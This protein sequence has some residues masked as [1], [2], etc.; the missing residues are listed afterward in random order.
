MT[1]GIDGQDNLHAL[2]NNTSDLIWSVDR[3]YKLISSNTA[4][5]EMVMHMTGKPIAKGS[6]V[7]SDG[8]TTGQLA[9]FRKSYARAFSGETFKVT[10][11]TAVP[12]ELWSELSFYPIRNGDKVVGTACYAHDITDFKKSQNELIVAHNKLV[13]HLENT[14][15]GFIEWDDQLHVKSWSKKAE[16]IFGWTELEFIDLQKSAYSQVYKEDLPWVSKIAHQLAN[17]EIERRS[18]RHRN[19]T[20]DGRVIWC[21]WFNS[22]LKDKNGK[23]MTIM[24]QVRDITKQKKAEEKIITAS[25][26]YAFISQVNQC[27]THAE[28]EETVIKDACRVAVEFGKFKEAW[29]GMMGYMDEGC[30]HS[31]C[32]ANGAQG[33]VIQ[34]GNCYVCNDIENDALLLDWKPFVSERGWRSCIIL[35]VKKSGTVGTFNIISSAVNFFQPEEVALLKEAAGDIS[36]SLSVFEKDKHRM[37]M[38]DKAVQSGL[39]LKQA[40]SIAHVG[41]WELNFSTG[42]AEWSEEMCRIYGLDSYENVQSYDA[43]LSFIHP[44]DLEYVM[45]VSKEGERTFSN[46]SFYHRIIRKNGVIRHIL[47]QAQVEFNKESS[48]VGLTGVAHDITEM[49]ETEKALAQSEA[50]LLQIMDLMPQSIFVKDYNG[51]VVFANKSFASLYGLST[52]Q[53]INRTLTEIMPVKSEAEYLLHQDRDVILSGEATTTPE[54]SFTDYGGNKHL[55]HTLKVPFTVVGTNEKAVLGLSNDITEQK[56]A[57]TERTRMVADIVRRNKDLEQFSYI[58]SHNVRAPVANINGITEILQMSGLDKNDRERWIGELASS[59]KKLDEVIMDLNHI[60]K[61]THT[62]S[63]KKETV[64]FSELLNDIKLGFNNLILNNGVEIVSDFSAV[65][66][67]LTLRSYLY[68]IFFNLVSNSIKYRRPGIKPVVEITSARLDDKI[69]LIFKDNGLGM[70]LKKRGGQVFGLYKRFHWHVEGKGM[71][72]YMVKTQVESLGGKIGISSEVNKGT[73]FRIEFEMA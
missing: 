58:V 14:T 46:S 6:D 61:V 71:G 23:V 38:E 20:K 36:F 31:L 52:K 54:F 73:E 15:L 17:G 29:I 42:I 43:W 34:T 28:N 72:L 51:K 47:S 33:Q 39:R 66:E 67:M 8:F 64:K 40:Q 62:E 53:M 59:V 25:H 69:Q 27:I 65:D 1:E 11:Y 30:P 16:E 24:S 60:L 57:E 70:D 2:I 9:R 12:E 18:V 3:N 44:E 10:E 41:S 68:S 63:D 22:V 19:Y 48:A 56:L 45:K 50:N 35:P 26:L 5:D 32:E 13:F 4:F 37:L 55:F 49:K 7:L 21:E